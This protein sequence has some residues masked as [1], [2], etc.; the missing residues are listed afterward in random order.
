[1]QDATELAVS[2]IYFQPPRPRR[3]L[4]GF[5]LDGGLTESEEDDGESDIKVAYLGNGDAANAMQEME[6]WRGIFQRG[7][8]TRTSLISIHDARGQARWHAAAP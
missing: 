6:E 2:A 1:M 8:S 4:D 7:V 3:R 5:A